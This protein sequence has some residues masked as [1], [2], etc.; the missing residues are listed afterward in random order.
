MRGSDAHWHTT[1]KNSR[2]D[3]LEMDDAVYQCMLEMDGNECHYFWRNNLEE[4]A[5]CLVLVIQERLYIFTANAW[6]MQAQHH[7]RTPIAK[8]KLSH[9]SDT[10]HT[11]GISRPHDLQAGAT[12]SSPAF[13]QSVRSSRFRAHN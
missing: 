12:R 4:E 13:G 6:L 2:K 11:L 8:H 7:V 5:R 9:S 3:A 10:I 1:N